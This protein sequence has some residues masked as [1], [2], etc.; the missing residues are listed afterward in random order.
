MDSKHVNSKIRESVRPELRE[1]GFTRFTTRDA[2]R[3]HDDRIDVLNFQSFNRY[4]ADV[5]GVT[6][7][8]FSVNLGCLYTDIPRGDGFPICK[9]TKNGELRPR[10]F[11]CQFRGSLKPRIAQKIPDERKVWYIDPEGQTLA[12]VMLDVVSQ[13]S[14]VAAPWY[15]NFSDI[16]NT[17]RIL[18]EADSDMDNIWGFGNNPSPMRDY[19]VGHFAV[20]LGHASA[21][22]EHL[23]RAIDSGCFEPSADR[24]L[25]EIRR[26]TNA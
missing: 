18:V 7:Y 3:Y 24:M 2:W 16:S 5:M 6:T 25:N 19:L 17:Y 11:E 13:I 8:S 12:A 4:H 9:T 10:E 1:H 22:E 26:I 23:R 15:D 14:T 21:A 20:R